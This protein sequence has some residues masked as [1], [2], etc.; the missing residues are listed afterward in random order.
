MEITTPNAKYWKANVS[1]LEQFKQ[2]IHEGEGEKLGIKLSVT[3]T[4][5]QS[6]TNCGS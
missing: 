4:T 1:T 6:I 5:Y 3:K 2:P